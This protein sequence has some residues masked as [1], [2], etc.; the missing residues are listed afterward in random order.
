M[1]VSA[2]IVGARMQGVASDSL[3]TCPPRGL[4]EAGD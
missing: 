2:E 1:I 3:I 4:G